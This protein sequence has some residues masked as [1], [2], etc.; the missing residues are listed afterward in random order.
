M[1]WQKLFT[2]I[3]IPITETSFGIAHGDAH[4]GNFMLEALEDNQFSQTTIDFDNSQKSWYIVDPG[5][6]L[7]HANLAMYFADPET[8]PVHNE[9]MKKWWIEAYG[10]DTTEAELEQG[11]QWRH[12]FMY[13]L[14]VFSFAT[15]KPGDDGYD[16]MVA[17][18]KL[19]QEGHIP[20]C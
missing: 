3:T 9:R 1:G 14:S 2:P 18:L 12:D 15:M 7:Y 5:T 19:N 10:W 16:Q 4:T 20:T 8:R 6:V 17:W 13:Y 11:C